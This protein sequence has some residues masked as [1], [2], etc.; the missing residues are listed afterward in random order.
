MKYKSLQQVYGESVIGNIPPRRHL[1]MLGEEVEETSDKNAVRDLATKLVSIGKGGYL[2]AD[3]ILYLNQYLDA[4]SSVP[5]IKNYLYSKNITEKTLTDKNAIEGI[6]NI[7]NS[8]GLEKKE[9]K[10][11]NTV[12]LVFFF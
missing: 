4:R 12:I 7:L 2:A 5:F 9:V 8:I 3:D 11:L 10:K 6:T 1:R